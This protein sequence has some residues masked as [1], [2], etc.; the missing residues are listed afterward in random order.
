[1]RFKRSGIVASVL[2]VF[3]SIVIFPGSAS[4]DDWGEFYSYGRRYCLTPEGNGTANGTVITVWPCASSTTSVQQFATE[5]TSYGS[6]IRHRASGRCVTPRGDS[7]ANGAVLTLW[8]CG[9]A[10]SQRWWTNTQHQW[11]GAYS[12][13]CFTPDGE[14]LGN[15]VWMTQWD[16]ATNAE[17][18]AP[19][20]IWW[21]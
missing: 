11:Y 9:S 1:M 3:A 8:D 7:T 2:L 15:G 5:S 17:M 18:N 16:C 10:K 12:N 4:A 13:K 20:Q 14:K 19:T 6:R 21:Y